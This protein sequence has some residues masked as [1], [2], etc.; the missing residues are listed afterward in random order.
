MEINFYQCDESLVKSIAPLTLKILEE[1]K[2]AFVFAKDQIRIKEIDDGLWSY[3]KNKFIPHVTVFD[4]D[5]ELERQPIF[6]SN[7]EENS[8]Q[9]DYLILADL[10]SEGFL[11]SFSR[12]F[13]FFD[14]LDLET[15]KAA[16]K[17][18]QKLATKF[19]SYK[20]E[21]NKWVKSEI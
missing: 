3:G 2:K 4:K 5:F 13:Y 11:Q 9:A 18:Y 8:N 20:K 10:A 7:K 12:I 1:N 17:K 6:L 21:D 19:N 16:A 14:I 15:A